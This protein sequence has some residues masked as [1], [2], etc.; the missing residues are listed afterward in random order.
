MDTSQQNH[1]SGDPLQNRNQWVKFNETT[2]GEVNHNDEEQRSANGVAAEPVATIE[3]SS[4]T[5][6]HS[7]PVAVNSNGKAKL[8]DDPYKVEYLPNSD[9]LNSSSP[10][11]PGN[12][13]VHA[14]IDN[15][16]TSLVS[17]S[18]HVPIIPRRPNVKP[19]GE[20]L[21]CYPVHEWNLNFFQQ[22]VIF[23]VLFDL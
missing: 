18:V 12:S 17:S 15:R 13:S 19:F 11:S 14:I 9:S 4:S 3:P 10:Q 20:F 21:L 5:Q 6:V 16:P 22:M 1:T 8:E 7:P 23:Y 2:E